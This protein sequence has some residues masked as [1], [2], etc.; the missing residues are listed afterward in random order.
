MSKTIPSAAA[1]VRLEILPVQAVQVDVANARCHFRGQLGL[2][3]LHLQP[4]AHRDAVDEPRHPRAVGRADVDGDRRLAPPPKHARDGLVAPPSLGGGADGGADVGV[5]L[6]DVRAV[7]REDRVAGLEV[8]PRERLEHDELPP[9]PFSLRGQGLQRLAEV[10][11]AV[12]VPGVGDELAEH[13]RHDV[14]VIG[15]GRGGETRSQHCVPVGVDD[16]P[17][18]IEVLQDVPRLRHRRETQGAIAHGG[19]PAF[20]AIR[21]RR[22][23]D[24]GWQAPLVVGPEHVRNPRRDA[25]AE[26][27]DALVGRIGQQT[28]GR[29]TPLAQTLRPVDARHAA[30]ALEILAEAGVPVADEPGGFG[31]A[32]VGSRWRVGG[33]TGPHLDRRRD[34]R[35]ERAQRLGKVFGRRASLDGVET[36]DRERQPLGRD[37]LVGRVEVAHD[38]D[39]THERGGV[40]ERP[41]LQRR[42]GL[43]SCPRFTKDREPD[44]VDER[45]A[46]HAAE[47]HEAQ[48]DLRRIIVD[49]G[50]DGD[51]APAAL[52][53]GTVHHV[54][55]EAHLPAGPIDADPHLQDGG[56]P[57]REVDTRRHAHAA[58][59]EVFGRNQ[60]HEVAE[61]LGRSRCIG[62]QIEVQTGGVLALDG[63]VDGLRPPA[64]PGARGGDDPRDRR[65]LLDALEA[66]VVDLARRRMSQERDGQ[67]RS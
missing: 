18:G 17:V 57:T 66:G 15:H 32:E 47:E 14:L 16:I 11:V 21:L 64:R 33:G 4:D 44:I 9:D 37:A 59:T 30:G 49:L 39:Q 58:T 43:R 27:D 46:A 51:L 52:G 36:G 35:E 23:A 62:R 28:R 53:D 55:E 6:V 60:L 3:E 19:R 12:P 45:L 7:D 61:S 48:R 31:G 63:G 1:R 22:D 67:S 41:A 65:A 56:I 26:I 50:V 40:R 29:V 25:T 10:D 24:G 34:R 20:R 8:G 13:V 54:V 2:L 42:G 38:S 5:D